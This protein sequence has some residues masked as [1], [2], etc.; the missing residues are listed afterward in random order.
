MAH[1][2]G[3]LQMPDYAFYAW[4]AR[5]NGRSSGERGYAP[6]FSALV[7]DIDC[8]MREIAAKDGFATQDIALI[9]QSFG[10]VL[11]AAWVHDYAPKLRA[12][13][14]ASPAFSV[15][16]Y[17]PFAK[18]GIAFWQKVSGRFFVNS[19]VK[20]KFLT[21]DQER[22]ASFESDPLITRPDRLQHSGRTLPARRP[23][24]LRMP[25]RS[26]CRH[27]CFCREATGWCAKLHSTI[28]SSISAAPARNVTCCGDFSTI[29]SANAI[30]LRPW[31]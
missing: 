19:Y 18:E 23:G 13:V 28:S 15:K 5:G 22:I 1:L 6:S 27:S 16:L 24:S 10:A 31:S 12:M 26:P 9:A 7:R 14:L 4:D 8:F 3:E 25:A 11:A 30:G 29:H 17:V 2:V 20:A 21:H